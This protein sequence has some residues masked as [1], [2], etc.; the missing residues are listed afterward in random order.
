[1]ADVSIEELI[2]AA[3]IAKIELN[4]DELARLLAQL[5]AYKKWLEPLLEVNCSAYEPLLFGHGALNAMREDKA[6][7]NTLQGLGY[8]A[9]NYEDGF[10]LVPPIIE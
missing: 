9:A 1:M 6:E 3:E 8:Y 5:I 4:E 7:Q 2:K 10:Y